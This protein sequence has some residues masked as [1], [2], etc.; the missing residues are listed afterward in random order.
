MTVNET[1]KSHDEVTF[2]KYC[3]SGHIKKGVHKNKSGD[4]QLYKCHDCQKVFSANFGFRYR[5]FD[6]AVV[7]EALH[8]YYSGMS[9]Y[10]IP[11]LFEMRGIDVDASTIRRWVERYSKITGMYTDSLKPEVGKWYRA[12]EVWVKVN[13]K[14]Y[15]LFASMDDDARYWIASDLADNKFHH[16]A[17]DLLRTTKEYTGKTPS[18]FITDK[19][20]TYQKAS[21]KVFSNKTYHKADAGIKS[22]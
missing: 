17:D 18:V 12:D 5:R 15:Y 13:G 20:H 1:I 8:L 22:K 11:D 9:S 10:G 21:R 7:S 14:Q 3:K 6:L 16:N 2:C 19:L 4:V